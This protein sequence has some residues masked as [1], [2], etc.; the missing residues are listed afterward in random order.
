[1]MNP[2]PA[3]A[4]ASA[5]ASSG[6]AAAAVAAQQLQLQQLPFANN[7]GSI[8]LTRNQYALEC[9]GV[10]L[11]P[12]T[13]EVCLLFYPDTSE[14]RLPIGR[15]DTMAACN[16][17]PDASYHPAEPSVSGCEPPAHSAQR[18]ITQITGY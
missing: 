6:A 15:P 8:A 9:G 10:L 14:W 3:T 17:N 18:L 12:S 11:D 7:N 13:N 1:M 2:S 16:N 5:T 4:S